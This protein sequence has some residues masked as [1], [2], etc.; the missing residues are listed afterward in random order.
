MLKL[1]HNVVTDT[2]KIANA[3]NI[4]CVSVLNRY[5]PDMKKDINPE[6]FRKMSHFAEGK[7]K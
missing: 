4:Y 2:G 3:L 6:T 1:E 5:I 7:V